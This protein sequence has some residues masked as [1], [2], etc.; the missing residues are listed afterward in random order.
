MP[1]CLEVLQNLMEQYP[2]AVLAT[3]AECYTDQSGNP[4]YLQNF[5]GKPISVLHGETMLIVWR[6][7][8]A[9]GEIPVS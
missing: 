7:D 2:N 6:E 5:F 1:R 3:S 9:S 4:Q 8:T